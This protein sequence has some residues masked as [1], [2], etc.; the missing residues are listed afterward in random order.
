MVEF[1][2][3]QKENTTHLL[4]FPQQYNNTKGKTRI[5]SF[6]FYNIRGF[7]LFHFSRPRDTLSAT[8]RSW[9]C[10]FQIVLSCF[11][12]FRTLF[13][14]PP[15]VHK[16][17]RSL[18]INF[19]WIGQVFAIDIFE[20][21]W[22]TTGKKKVKT[23]IKVEKRLIFSF[24]FSPGRI[25]LLRR[26]FTQKGGRRFDKCDKKKAKFLYTLSFPFTLAKFRKNRS[27][28]IWIFH[29][30]NLDNSKTNLHRCEKGEKKKYSPKIDVIRT[31]ES[32]QIP[33]KG[34]AITS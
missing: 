16:I 23:G 8:G 27:I 24:Y 15:P 14:L 9:I 29:T 4:G 12:L 1:H 33:K 10:V 19:Y 6:L 18:Y 25:F 5:F 22:S 7:C 28:Y 2:C 34:S 11:D 26:K 32:W 21:E 17:V 30:G 13:R 20:L 3:R 31:R